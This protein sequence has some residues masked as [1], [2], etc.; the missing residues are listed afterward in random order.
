VAEHLRC[1]G[2]DVIGVD[3]S[4]GM[5]AEARRLHP[6]VPVV[7]G[8][9][10]RLPVADAAAAG[11]LA[12]YSV[13]HTAPADLPRV[14]AE[15]VRVVALGA[16]VLVAFQCG[17]GERVDRTEAFGRQ[18]RRT[19]Y[20]HRVDLVAALLER[21]GVAVTRSVVREPWAEH[22]TTPQGFVTGVRRA[23]G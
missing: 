4:V 16:P 2:V 11:V 13:I 17:D 21:H 14:V 10:G 9:L 19:N 23:A 5:L 18:V 8:A 22:E 20:R 1:R 3:L 6:E 12:W 7:L 15:L